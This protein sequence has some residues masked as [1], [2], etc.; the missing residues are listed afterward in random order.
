[1]YQLV[2]AIDHRRGYIWMGAK[3]IQE[4]SV[5][6]F[7][8]CFEPKTAVKKLNLLKRKK[9]TPFWPPLLNSTT[10]HVHHFLFSVWLKS[11]ST[12]FQHTDMHLLSFPESTY[13]EMPLKIIECFLLCMFIRRV[14]SFTMVDTH[15]LIRTAQVHLER[16]KHIWELLAF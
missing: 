12:T 7:H 2:R 15:V 1:M 8:F 4:V 9:V 14:H 13:D 10:I 5:L 16:R 3:G 6:S 11:L